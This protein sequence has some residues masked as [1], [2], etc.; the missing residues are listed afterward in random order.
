MRKAFHM[1]TAVA[2]AVMTM[3]LAPAAAAQT[4]P[5]PRPPDAFLSSSSG[6]VKGEVQAFCWIEVDPSGSGRGVCADGL[7]P[8]HP[9]QAVVVDQGQFLSLRF[10]R[11]IPPG[12]ITVSRRETSVSFPPIQQFEVPADNP[13][14]F[15]AD[16]PPGTHILT[17]L[18][19]WAPGGA[20]HGE[21]IYVF[22]VTVRPRP[23][24]G[25]L[26]PDVRDAL[27]R[28]AEA[29]RQLHAGD[30]SFEQR[31]ATL[32][33]ARAALVAA[34]REMVNVPRGAGPSSEST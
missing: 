10:D 21:A 15:R 9:S 3:L 34:L 20:A 30:G 13:T 31:R 7:A 8:I 27:A 26:T 24:P 5:P 17:V 1:T 23:A 29:S 2:V 18:A 22:K 12:S 33:A 25:G 11:P 28:L 32:L 14:R 4:N 16:F 19:R 6:E